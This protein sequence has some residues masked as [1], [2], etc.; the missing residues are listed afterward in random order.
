MISGKRWSPIS[1]F[2]SFVAPHGVLVAAAAEAVK[3]ALA[4]L[5]AAEAAQRGEDAAQTW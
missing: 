5:V 3:A 4:G 2:I 1:I